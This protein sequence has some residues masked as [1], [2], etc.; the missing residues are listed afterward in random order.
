M[1]PTPQDY[2]FDFGGYI[3]RGFKV[4]FEKPLQFAGITLLFFVAAMVSNFIPILGTF[5]FSFAVSP[6]IT[7]GMG[8]VAHKL[9]KNKGFEFSDFFRGFDYIGQLIVVALIQMAFYLVIGGIMLA[10]IGFDMVLDPTNFD[11]VNDGFPF[12][13][14]LLLLPVIYLSV[15][16]V[17]APYYIVFH[18][19]KAWSAMEASREVVTRKWFMF[20]IFV[21]ALSFLAMLGAIAVFVGLLITI[22][23]IY[24]SLYFA[25]DDIVGTA[26][27]VVTNTGD[28][29]LL[30]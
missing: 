15:A 1:L 5:A 28:H 7:V 27:G 25:F 14:L 19:A 10:I 22:P 11:P 8:I 12:W 2:T 16:W 13:S 23:V 30:D 24:T 20:L 26:E 3:S 29:F 4:I 18:N 9:H 21:I 6:A 17:F